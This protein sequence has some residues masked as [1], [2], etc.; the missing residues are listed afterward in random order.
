VGEERRKS[1]RWSY[2]ICCLLIAL[3]FAGFVFS[4]D[5]YP[6]FCV[7]EP[8]FNEAAARRVSGQEYIHVVHTGVP[9]ADLVAANH[10]P[11]YT[12]LQ[13]VV[14]RVLGLSHFAC[15]FPGYLAAHAAVLTLGLFLL[16]RGLTRAALILACAWVGDRTTQVIMYGRPDGWCLLFIALALIG[17]VAALTRTASERRWWMATGLALGTAAGF[18]PL[19][20]LIFGAAVVAATILMLP[21]SRWRRAWVDVALGLLAPLA[22]VFACWAPHIRAAVAQLIWYVRVNRDLVPPVGVAARALLRI[23]PFT[24]WAQ[25]WHAGLAWLVLLMAL[26]P[27]IHAVRRSRPTG[28]WD[29]GSALA[30]VTT[31]FSLAGLLLVLNSVSHPSYYLYFTPLATM[32]LAVW[33]IQGPSC[34]L[35]SSLR[36]VVGIL[37]VCAWG[38]SLG[39]NVMRFREARLWYGMLDKQAIV[40]ELE[41]HV[42]RGTEI[43]G[44]PIFFIVARQ[45]GLRFTP[46]PWYGNDRSIRIQPSDWLVLSPDYLCVLNSVEPDWSKRRPL[47]LERVAFG[48]SPYTRQTYFIYGPE[49]WLPPAAFNRDV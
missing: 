34:Q 21:A 40:R 41:R 16:T 10:G 27:A 33:W 4:L 48:E 24:S 39:W 8:W 26:P 42:P 15:R 5:R 32:A 1:P 12:R 37:M 9:Y 36:R 49:G 18:Y 44:D 28:C 6:T 2:V 17:T 30:T 25:Y 23:W 35:L 14:F 20:A 45:A 29:F 7:D 13:V 46:L 38:P 11:F 43:R 47:R 22:L 31:L 3:P 19:I